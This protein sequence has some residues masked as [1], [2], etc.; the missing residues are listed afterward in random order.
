M[1]K[2]SNWGRYHVRKRPSG[3]PRLRLEYNVKNE[4]K[5]VEPKI[6]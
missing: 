6:R 4:T 1:I 3:G 5:T 2:G